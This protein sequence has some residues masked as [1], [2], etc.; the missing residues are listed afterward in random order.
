MMFYRL[1]GKIFHSRAVAILATC[2]FVIG[3]QQSALAVDNGPS[4]SPSACMQ[5]VFIGPSGN[6]SNAN[7]LNCT[8]NDIRL[9]RAI[10]VS[11]DSC[12]MGSHFN[13]TGTFE[14]IVTANARYDAGFFF[15]TDGGSTARGDG[16]SASGVCSLSQLTPGV[17]PSLNLDNDTCGDLNAGTYNVTFTIPNVLCQDTDGDGFLN[18]PNCTSWHSNQGTACT[19][20][21]SPYDANP[22]TK[23]KCVCDDTFQVPVRVEHPNIGV[24]KTA[25][26]TQVNEPGASV[27]F[28]VT[29]TNPAEATSVTLSTIVDDPDNNPATNNSVTYQAS[30]ICGKTLLGPNGDS[31]TCTFTRLVTGNAGANIT[32][33]ACV[34]AVDSNNNPVGPTCDT[35]TVSIR[36]VAPTAAVT[37]SVD[38]FVCAEI[39]YK[40][41]VENTD[42]AESLTLTSLV[43]DIFGNL[44]QV[45][46]SI[47]STNC[48]V[49]QT[50]AKSSSY[51]C[52]FNAKVCQQTAH[53]NTVTGTLHDDENTVITPSGSSSVTVTVTTP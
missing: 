10:S 36:D 42:T 27:T 14:T 48:S 8:A 33:E 26:P 13:L 5:R 11:Q 20:D 6:V 34:T 43:D 2:S 39:R 18:L 30:I 3:A 29:V 1:K 21:N 15:R 37:K 45:G 25:N 7:Q 17:S 50:I 4:I 46:G 9:S 19:L 16:A 24:V 52:T 31:T 12:I 35:A 53:V 51:S 40:V 41:K 47:V 22:D 23:S 44:T 49:D 38:A 28:T 32:D